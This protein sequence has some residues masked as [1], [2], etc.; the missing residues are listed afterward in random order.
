MFS[1]RDFMLGVFVTST[2]FLFYYIYRGPQVVYIKVPIPIQI[3]PTAVPAPP[4][5]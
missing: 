5:E 2:L 3:Q 1:L 4:A